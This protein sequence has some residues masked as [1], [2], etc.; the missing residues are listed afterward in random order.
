[1]GLAGLDFG[2]PRSSFDKFAHRYLRDSQKRRASLPVRAF[3][4][5]LRV[6][7]W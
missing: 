7:G 4:R 6:R 2:D 3:E 1:L 5:L